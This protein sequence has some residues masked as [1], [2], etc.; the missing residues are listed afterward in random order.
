MRN[1]QRAIF[2]FALSIACSLSAAH[3]EPK[4]PQWILSA[5][6]SPEVKRV[7]AMLQQ[8][9]SKLDYAKIK[10]TID[11]MIDPKL[12]VATG[13][14]RID[15]MIARIRSMLSATP[16]DKEKLTALTT[17]LYSPGQW[18]DYQPFRYDFN[19]P[20]GTKLSNK[21]LQNYIASRQGNC[22]SMPVLFII[23]GARLGLDLRGST[24]PMHFFV[25]YT[26]LDSGTTY[27]LEATSGALPSKNGINRKCP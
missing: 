18:N 22:V 27:N 1:L 25:K 14:K 5:K 6:T 13:M 26:D 10:L 12:D 2:I 4:T 20:M 19:D 3:A 8:P 16:S 23:L 15:D 17:Y 7:R 21:L 24:A 11:S 9:E